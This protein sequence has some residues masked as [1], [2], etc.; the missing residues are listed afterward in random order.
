MRP[1]LVPPTPRRSALFHR[2]AK[3]WLLL[4]GGISVLPAW[5]EPPTLKDSHRI[6]NSTLTEE[7]D[8]DW[9]VEDQGTEEHN[10]SHTAAALTTIQIDET[11]P[12]SSDLTHLIDSASGTTIVQLGGLGDFAGLSIR[13]SSLQQV[14]IFLDGI[15]LN[16]DGASTVNLAELLLWAFQRIEI[17]RSLPLCGWA[18]P[19]WAVP[20]TW[21]AKKVQPVV[22]FPQQPH[23]T[24][25]ARMHAATGYQS[26]ES[27]ST[28]YFSLKPSPQKATLNISTTTE[29]STTPAMTNKRGETTTTSSSCLDMDVFDGVTTR[30]LDHSRVVPVSRRG[31]PRTHPNR[32]GTSASHHPAQPIEYATQWSTWRL[33]NAGH[34]MVAESARKPGRSIGRGQPGTG[35]DPSP[36]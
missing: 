25:P 36:L 34:T 11:I 4:C 23:R 8:E 16:P 6:D 33:S 32:L 21:S 26:P 35:M 28:F 5:A 20:S 24:K 15:P 31:R 18:V 27:R 17:Y 2:I 14:E 19:P 1:S 10:P 3:P 30:L 9:V 13:G 7:V 22:R 29:P 12:Q